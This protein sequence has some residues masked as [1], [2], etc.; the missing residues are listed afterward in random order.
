METKQLMLITF[1]LLLFMDNPDLKFS[2]SNVR[3]LL[4]AGHRPN[5]F[6]TN[7]RTDMNTHYILPVIL[8]SL[9]S[10][11]GGGD[12]DTAEPVAPIDP[13]VPTEPQVPTEPVEKI[14]AF[15]DTS[16]G[17][18]VSSVAELDALFNTLANNGEDDIIYIAAG[19]YSVTK[20]LTYDFKTHNGE[21]ME[22]LSLY[23]CGVDQTIFDG[24]DLTRIF[25]FYKDGPKIDEA[26]VHQGPNPKLHI[27]DLT[28][29]N[30]KCIGDCSDGYGNSGAAAHVQRYDT[31][32]VRVH[33]LNNYDL[34]E[35]SALNGTG[36]TTLTEVV[37][38]GNE[39]STAISVCGRLTV[40]D[41]IISN[42]H[43]GGIHRGI[44]L[45]GNYADY[46]VN[47][48][49]STFEDNFG[50]KGF[51]QGHGGLQVLGGTSP[52]QLTIIDSVFKNNRTQDYGGAAVLTRHGNLTIIGSQFI[53][54]QVLDDQQECN[55]YTMDCQSGGALFIDNWF[56]G[57]GLI[58]IKDSIFKDNQ[59][60]DTGGA[61]DLG[62]Y[63]CETDIIRGYDG[64][65]SPNNYAKALQ[66]AI[67]LT[68]TDSTFTGNKAA[69]AANI[70]VAKTPLQGTTAFQSGHVLISHSSLTSDTG[71]TSV[72]VRGDLELI[73]TN[74]ANRVILNGELT[75]DNASSIG[76]LVQR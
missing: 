6:L 62:F 19:T 69:N 21:A 8:I 10:G 58:T 57:G 7:L 55:D 41:S 68:I 61:I 63:D 3:E 73:S 16:D 67:T 38:S 27:Q 29:Q 42:N 23:G 64:Y 14:C 26:K 5:D 36:H 74:I 52:G 65:C 37:V 32:L 35:G 72:I 30:G 46:D 9:L 15:Q 11:C 20:P 33:L 31:D 4:I 54:N 47:I 45:E 12:G 17:Y 71:E 53:G 49:R 44:C 50:Y 56:P 76:D 34:N 39:G 59:A 13:V 1:F 66:E 75:L 60:P 51:A 70:G 2:Y 28:I 25:N 22:K 43:G 24:G 18:F 48:I 40:T